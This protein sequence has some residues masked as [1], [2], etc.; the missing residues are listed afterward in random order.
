M[1]KKLSMNKCHFVAIVAILTS[2]LLCACGGPRLPL[3]KIRTSLKGVPTYS[4][5]LDDMKEEGNLFKTHYYKY[6]IILEDKTTK[7][8][9]IEVPENYFKQNVSFLGMTIWAKKDG[10]ES[11]GV[12]PPGYLNTSTR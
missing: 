2:F 11:K 3:D 12:G 4:I 10:K 7:T 5:V 8:D 6:S 9:W 1:R